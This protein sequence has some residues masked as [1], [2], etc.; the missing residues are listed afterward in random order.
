MRIFCKRSA[1]VL[2]LFSLSFQ[3]HLS[4]QSGVR[5]WMKGSSVSDA[6]DDGVTHFSRRNGQ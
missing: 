2:L 4:A 3:G 1:A 6:A 5:T